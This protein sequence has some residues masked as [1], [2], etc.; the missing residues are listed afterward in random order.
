MSASPE[1]ALSDAGVDVLRGRLAG[2][3]ADG[4]GRAVISSDD[5]EDNGDDH[6]PEN[7]LED[8]NA[9]DA[10]DLVDE[11]A[12][13]DRAL[14]RTQK[15]LSSGKPAR[16]HFVYD[17]DWDEDKK[18]GE[19]RAVMDRTDDLPPVLA[20]AIA[21]DAWEQIDPLQHLHWLGPLLAAAQLRK[22]G[23]AR[24]HLPCPSSGLRAMP[25]ERRR[26]RDRNERLKALIESF[27]AGAAKGLQDHDRW[28][29][30]R[31]L[32][33]RKLARRRSTSKLPALI[34][35]VITRPIVSA[36]MIAKELAI[37]PRAAQ[38]LVAELGLREA[39]GKRRYRAWGII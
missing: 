32:L 7:M 27:A 31:R 33:E 30:A 38:D 5:D 9:D 20:A 35:Y 22:R 21:I 26:A 17:A 23:K 8:D 28:L 13:L 10:F 16:D 11:F 37:T 19:W 1:W 18:L 6:I 12:E 29:L 24:V 4:Q 34:D 14:A 15:L 39:T 36:G 2:A 25:L 3:Q